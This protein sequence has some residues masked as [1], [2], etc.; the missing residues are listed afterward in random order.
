[1]PTRVRN[2][3]P[4]IEQHQIWSSLDH[5]GMCIAP[6]AAHRDVEAFVD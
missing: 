5:D 2:T 6:R 3:E 1:M 4:R